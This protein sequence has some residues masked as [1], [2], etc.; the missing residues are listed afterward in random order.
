MSHVN[1]IKSRPLSAQGREN[2]DRIFSKKNARP[3]MQAAV[4]LAKNRQEMEDGTWHKTMEANRERIKEI[5]ESPG[6]FEDIP[7]ELNHHI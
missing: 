6:P 2:Y 3:F 5:Y 7:T 1:P 4:I